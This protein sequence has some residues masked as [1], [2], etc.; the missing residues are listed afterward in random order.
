M[1]I[2]LRR[3][4]IDGGSKTYDE[5]HELPLSHDA[6]LLS[7]NLIDMKESTVD[8]NQTVKNKML[9]EA[10]LRKTLAQCK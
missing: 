4:R 8:G 1:L 2:S 9:L 6:R 3:H 10:T 5:V 7:S